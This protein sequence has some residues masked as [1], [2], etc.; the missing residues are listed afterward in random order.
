MEATEQNPLQII[1]LS[2]KRF[3]GKDYVSSLIIDNLTS[4]SIYAKR[5]ALADGCK[6]GFAAETPGIS[7]E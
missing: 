7:A 6:Y 3:C 4:K 2:G 1:F 5:F